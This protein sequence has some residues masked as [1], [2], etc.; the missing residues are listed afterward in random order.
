MGR[1]GTGGGGDEAQRRGTPRLNGHSHIRPG[2]TNEAF[3][4][5]ASLAG[6]MG[7][8]LP[9]SKLPDQTDARFRRP[10]RC[11]AEVLYC[12]CHLAECHSE[13][14]RLHSPDHYQMCTVIAP[15]FFLTSRPPRPRPRQIITIITQ[16]YK[17]YY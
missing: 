1:V 2:K 9:R 4:P 16:K 8:L 14:C 15:L 12:T 6:A 10:Q 13:Y 5:S 7:A 3:N 17:F 11:G